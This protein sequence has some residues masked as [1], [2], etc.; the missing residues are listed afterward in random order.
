MAESRCRGDAPKQWSRGSEWPP[1]GLHASNHWRLGRLLSGILFVQ[2]RRT[3]TTWLRAAGVR[4]VCQ[5][6]SYFLTPLGHKAKLVATRLAVMVIETLPV[7]EIVHAAL[8]DSP[9]ILL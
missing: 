8:D 3:V 9:T 2:E 7:G 4:D 6:D 5:D 1:T